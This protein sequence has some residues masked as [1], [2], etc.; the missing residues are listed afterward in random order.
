MCKVALVWTRLR[1]R[2]GPEKKTTLYVPRVCHCIF[3]LSL[4]SLWHEVSP[5]KDHG[6]RPF[7][8]AAG[9]KRT[10]RGC[11]LDVGG[12]VDEDVV[13][14]VGDVAVI[15]LAVDIDVAVVVDV[16]GNGLYWCPAF[17]SRDVVPGL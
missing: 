11:S 4:G 1:F 2:G 12:N 9:V 16:D 5:D 15:D 8:L 10:W 14:D 3:A 7:G 17:R 13:V 6:D